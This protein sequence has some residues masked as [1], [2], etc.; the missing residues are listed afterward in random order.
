M[1]AGAE[2]SLN[3]RRT[4]R[5]KPRSS[6][7]IFEYRRVAL[8]PAGAVTERGTKFGLKD[9]LPLSTSITPF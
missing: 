5:R 2:T 8:T 1:R 4:T 6:A 7:R 3:A 9:A